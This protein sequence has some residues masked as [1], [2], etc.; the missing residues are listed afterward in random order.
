MTNASITAK[1]DVDL[2]LHLPT[3]HHGKVKGKVF[4]LL[5]NVMKTYGGVDV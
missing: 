2:Y 4:P 1:E 3:H 5:N